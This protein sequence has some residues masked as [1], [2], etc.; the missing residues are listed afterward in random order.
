MGPRDLAVIARVAEDHD[1]TVITDEIYEYFRFDGRRHISPASLPEL[2]ARPVTIMGMSKTFSITGWRLG[3]AV[4]PEPWARAITLVHDLYYVCAPTPLQHGVV[5]GFAA[6]PSFFTGLAVTYQRKRD[7]ICDALEAARLHPV[8]PEGAYYVLADATP[9][10]CATARE[11]AMRVLEEAGVA[12]V[13]GTAFYEG[14][15]G[16]RWLRF[17]FG[18]DDEALGEACRRIR[19]FR[20]G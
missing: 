19:G 3:Y 5:E 6:P 20:G 16:E 10:G 15:T 12:S 11:A 14:R 17:C 2:G 9:L 8:V 1:L 7:Q 13:P 18:K 4:A